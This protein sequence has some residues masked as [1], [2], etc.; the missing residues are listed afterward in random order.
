MEI[1]YRDKDKDIDILQLYSPIYLPSILG[2]TIATYILTSIN[3]HTLEILHAA[4][5]PEHCN[6]VNIT[7]KQVI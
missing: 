5:V 1:R 7:I 3:R 6:K 4:F 2:A